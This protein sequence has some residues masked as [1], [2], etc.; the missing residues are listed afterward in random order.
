MILA[1]LEHH[2][3]AATTSAVEHWLADEERWDNE[4]PGDTWED[5]VT[6]KGYAPWEVRVTCPHATTRSGSSSSS[7]WRATARSASGST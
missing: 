5:E 1:E 7:K 6:E 2:G 4:P 3:I